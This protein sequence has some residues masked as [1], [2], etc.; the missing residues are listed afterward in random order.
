MR[1]MRAPGGSLSS[2]C[3]RGLSRKARALHRRLS[4]RRQR[5]SHRP[6]RRAEAHRRPGAPVR[7]RQSRRRGRHHRRGNRRTLA[8]RGFLAI[9]ESSKRKPATSRHSFP[10]HFDY[11]ALFQFA[12]RCSTAASASSHTQFALARSP[13][14]DSAASF[15]TSTGSSAVNA[16]PRRRMRPSTTTV[17]ML[18]GCANETSA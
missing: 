7:R 2:R 16:P 14:A 9:R 17:S 1:A 11:D 18:L 13:A 8:Q 6:P 10:K 5:R 15:S 12:R 4:A 3:S